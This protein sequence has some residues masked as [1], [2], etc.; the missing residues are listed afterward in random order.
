MVWTQVFKSGDANVRTE[1]RCTQTGET[2][3]FE[4]IS[5]LDAWQEE[6]KIFS[7]TWTRRIGRDLI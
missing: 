4:V 3:A 5:S 7:R 2:N 1:A 6:E